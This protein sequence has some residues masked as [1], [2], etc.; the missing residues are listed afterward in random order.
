MKLNQKATEFVCH[1]AL[2]PAP[3][4]QAPTW[5]RPLRCSPMASSTHPVGSRAFS[6]FPAS[7]HCPPANKCLLRLC[8]C[9]ATLETRERRGQTHPHRGFHLMEGQTLFL[10]Q[11]PP[12]PGMLRLR[13]AGRFVSL[14]AQGELGRVSELFK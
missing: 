4:K 7:L 1:L 5:G 6:L 13:C 9:Q 8:S 2:P 14:P 3:P 11:H 10:S 12:R